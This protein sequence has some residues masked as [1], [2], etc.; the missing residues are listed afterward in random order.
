MLHGVKCHKDK[1]FRVR[2]RVGSVW[3]GDGVL[4]TV[5]GECLGKATFE[6]T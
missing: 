3:T 5:F 2:N 4:N 6:Q 1:Q